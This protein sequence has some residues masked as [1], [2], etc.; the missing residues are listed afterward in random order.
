MRPYF[1]QADLT[2]SSTKVNEP[3]EALAREKQSTET[4]CDG[5]PA[6]SYTVIAQSPGGLKG[7]RRVT[8]TG[9][10]ERRVTILLK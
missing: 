7:K 8:L 1:W 4:C 10:S 5:Q 3:I 2:P 6:G 9:G